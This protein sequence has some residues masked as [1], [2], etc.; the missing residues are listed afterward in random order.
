[1]GVEVGDLPGGRFRGFVRVTGERL[2]EVAGPPMRWE[3]DEERP[4]LGE[5]R[6]I[7]WSC[8]CPP[9]PARWLRLRKQF[10]QRVLLHCGAPRQRL[11]CTRGRL[12][13]NGNQRNKLT[14]MTHY[15]AL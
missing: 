7:R 10:P 12:C 5:D 1:M 9:P 13:F 15:S 4:K 3:P 11:N 6:I 8:R 2:V 14:P